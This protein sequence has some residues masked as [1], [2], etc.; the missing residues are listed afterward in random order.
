VQPLARTIG[1]ALGL[2]ALERLLANAADC[3]G[4]SEWARALLYALNIRMNLRGEPLRQGIAPSGP[5]VVVSNHPFGILEPLL[6]MALLQPLYPDLRYIGQQLWQRMAN[7]APLLFPLNPTTGYRFQDLNSHSLRCAIR[8]VRN[9]H[10]LA[11]FPAPRVATWSWAHRGVV[12]PPWSNLLGVLVARAH[13]DVIPMHFAGR[14]SLLFQASAVLLDPL[15]HALLIREFL[16]KKNQTIEITVGRRMP[17][18]GLGGGTDVQAMTER[19][20]A[21]LE[22]LGR[23]AQSGE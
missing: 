10:A 7:V 13:A 6:M 5:L 20:R 3:G 21:I 22:D 15:H 4:V 2:Q 19:V 12:D 16:N 8:W 18:K 17:W 11:L 23:Q 14:N 1:G 9:G